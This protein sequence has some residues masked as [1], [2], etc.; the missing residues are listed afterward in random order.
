MNVPN[1]KLGKLRLET[2]EGKFM[3][4]EYTW[5]SKCKLMG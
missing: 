2:V 4:A 5:K 3:V 1:K